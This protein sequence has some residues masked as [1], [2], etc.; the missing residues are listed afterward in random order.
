MQLLILFVIQITLQAFID[1]VVKSNICFKTDPDAW[2]S[3]NEDGRQLLDPDE[4][5]IH[6]K[7][8]PEDKDLQ[9]EWNV[10]V[11]DPGKYVSL[12]VGQRS[13]DD[14]WEKMT[15]K[16]GMILDRGTATRRIFSWRIIR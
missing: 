8:L 14:I 10:A 13:D 12:L 9:D 6:R 11:R 16:I 5:V 7:L 1:F 4:L 3:L 15:K 2:R